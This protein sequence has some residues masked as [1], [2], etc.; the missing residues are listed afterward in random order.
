MKLQLFAAAGLLAAC[1]A[2]SGGPYINGTWTSTPTRIDNEIAM[3]SEATSVLTMDF[4]AP[5]GAKSGGVTL[6]AVINANQPVEAG[7][8]EGF[9]EP[10]E[11]SVTATATINGQWS[12]EGDDRDDIVI[13]LDR[14]TLTVTVDPDG[15]TYSQNLLTGVEQP[16]V[17][18][19]TAVTAERWRSAVRT[20]ATAQFV[21]LD[22]L[23]DVKVKGDILSCEVGKRDLT[24]RRGM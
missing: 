9:D 21:A 19:L 2:C 1:T 4:D 12:R 18:S 20:A 10:Y 24:F 3:A 7:A 15:V 8:V 23:D 22:K 17:D 14:N 5:K 6:S 16:R 11:V 13:F